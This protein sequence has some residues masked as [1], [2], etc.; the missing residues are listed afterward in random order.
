[1]QKFPEYSWIVFELYLFGEF[2]VKYIFVEI[3]IEEISKKMKTIK[4]HK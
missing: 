2:F 4:T 3:V 1:M